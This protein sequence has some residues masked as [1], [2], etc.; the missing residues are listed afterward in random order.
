MAGL[1]EKKWALNLFL[2]DEIFCKLTASLGLYCKPVS[3]RAGVRGAGKGELA[4][5]E[6]KQLEKA[7]RSR[8]CF[9]EVPLWE[10]TQTTSW[11]CMTL[12]CWKGSPGRRWLVKRVYTGLTYWDDDSQSDCLCVHLC[13]TWILCRSMCPTGEINGCIFFYV[14]I[15]FWPL[16]VVVMSVHQ[17]APDWNISATAGRIAMKFCTNSRGPQRMKPWVLNIKSNISTSTWCI[18]TKCTDIHGS[19]TITEFSEIDAMLICLFFSR[20][21]CQLLGTE[22]FE[23]LF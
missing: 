22:L 17:F 9:P 21:S 2:C 4:C 15:T 1:K 19:Q 13:N 10:S 3:D 5:W 12:C 11:T 23:W 8:Q 7:L 20:V 14:M 6:P 18:G 16:V